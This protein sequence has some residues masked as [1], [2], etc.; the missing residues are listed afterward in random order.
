MSYL[1]PRQ[2]LERGLGP[3]VM[4]LSRLGVHPHVLTL[5]GGAGNLG[6]AVLVARGHFLA[7]G[8]LMWGAS[9]LDMLDGALA[10]A[11]GR[12]SAF[13]SVLDAVVDRAAEA[14]LFFALLFRFTAEGDREGALLAFVAAIASF[15]V[16][17]VRARAE[18]TGIAMREGVMARPERVFLL[19]LGLIIDHVKP[20]LW[21][22]AVLAS[23]TAAQ[24]FLLAWGRTARGGGEHDPP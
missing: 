21:V 11:T 19:G 1:L 24:R 15:M 6:A 4:V 23:L 5:A 10:R 7:G 2:A 14:A 17:Y 22:L 18:L 12:Q 9:A 3:L 20:V 16:S 13:G 8:A